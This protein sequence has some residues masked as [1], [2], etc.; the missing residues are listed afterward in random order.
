MDINFP[1]EKLL[2]KIIDTLD[3]GVGAF[4]RPW[5]ITREGKARAEVFR[6]EK[7]AIAQAELEA[8]EIRQGRKSF[9][10]GELLALPAPTK[11]GDSEID[12]NDSISFLTTAKAEADYRMIKRAVN[13]RKIAVIAEEEAGEIPDK[14]VSDEP[15]DLDWFARWREAAQDVSNEEMQQLWARL[16]SG[17]VKKPGSYSLQ[18]V[19]LLRNLSSKQAGW[20]AALAPFAVGSWIFKNCDEFLN[21]AG[22]NFEVLLE[23]ESLGILTGLDAVGGINREINFQLHSDNEDIYVTLLPAHGVGVLITHEAPPPKI[24][25]P[26]YGILSVGQELISL[27]QFASNEDYLK[28]LGKFFVEK[29]C[30]AFLVDAA[31]VGGNQFTTSNYRPIK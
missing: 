16:L 6:L 9:V 19:S 15:V 27:G 13:L 17:E 5:Q 3:K 25:I 4:A 1:G 26:I 30:E 14:E 8:G 24:N 29:G 28:K 10:N 22:L 21:E 11:I 12:G 31:S 20:I 2:I 18:S 23:L 7:L